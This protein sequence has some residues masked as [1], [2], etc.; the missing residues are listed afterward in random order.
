[1]PNQIT[2][3]GLEV[4]TQAE[5]ITYFTDAFQTIYGSDIDLSQDTPDG[6]MMMIFIQAVLDMSDLLVQINNG[7]DPDNAIGVTLDQRVALNGIQR[8]GG[9]HTIT[10]ITLVAT[11]ACNLFGVDQE[12]ESIYTVQDDA[13]NEWELLTSQV[14]SAAGT[15]VYEFQAKNP[16]AV[17][18][19]PNTITSPV[20]IVLGIQTINNPDPYSSL[21][22]NQETDAELKV[23]RQISVA[24]GSQGYL[25]G[26]VAALENIDG[27]TYS[28]VYENTGDATDADGVP[29]HSIWVIVAGAAADA[30]IANAI[31]LKRNAGC[32]MYGGESYSITQVDGTAFSVF[33][34]VVVPEDVF[35]KFTA[36]SLDGD[37]PPDIAAIRAGLPDSFLPGV[38]AQVNINDLATLVQAIDDNTLVT[39]A[40]FSLT[41]GGSY[42]NTLSPSVK[43]NQF[44]VTEAKI[45]IIPMLM[46]PP[47]A[48]LDSLA[49]QQ[50]T[51]LGG[52]GAYTWTMD[53]TPSGGSVSP[54]G[55]YTAGAGT[56][57]DVVRATD[58]LANYVTANVVVT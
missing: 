32:G 6:Q 51:A 25:E 57:T 4:N 15:Y 48:A 36:T 29:G 38:G 40:G 23:R 27:L 14:I 50:F 54:T 28:A 33:W 41:S 10:D 2:S 12:D 49:T 47:S 53:A 5:W 20:T 43:K 52:Y 22:I 16:G 1:M 17:L 39:V 58:T 11:A 9:T 44:I 19:V 42:T 24:L 34:D 37:N 35:I 31:Y 7:F 3:A 21:G 8:Q 45:I 46:S 56:G 55:L 26:L 18:T 13:G 30:D